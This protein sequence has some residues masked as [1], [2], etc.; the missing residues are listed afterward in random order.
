[1]KINFLNA[2]FSSAHPKNQ[3]KLFLLLLLSTISIMAAMRI[4]NAHLV[5]PA[6]PAGIISFEFSLNLARSLLI[7]DSWGQE[8]SKYAFYSLGLDF[9]FLIFYS[10]TL[11]LACLIT[12]RPFKL[13]NGPIY[14]LSLFCAWCMFSAAGLDIIENIALGM[15]LLGAGSD[16]GASIAAFSAALKFTLIAGTIIYLIPSTINLFFIRKK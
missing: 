6:A 4:I 10:S 7:I 1:M 12:G 3:N 15:I 11:A 14:K 16:T 8:G 13:K 2:P 5:T 9:I